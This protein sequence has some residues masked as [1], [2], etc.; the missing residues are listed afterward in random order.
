M[1]D[2]EEKR[3]LTK[4]EYDKIYYQKH[5]K[6]RIA[7]SRKWYR[8]N[9]NPNAKRHVFFRSEEEKKEM[10][11]KRQREYYQKHKKILKEKYNN[12]I[13]NKSL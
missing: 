6:E 4:K 2:K 5:K 11:A 3:K 7:R 9:V 10:K 12:A 8:D 1:D 13:K